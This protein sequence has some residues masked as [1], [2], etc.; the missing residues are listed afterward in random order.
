[1]DNPVGDELM[2]F[3]FGGKS[4][5]TAIAA[6]SLEEYDHKLRPDRLGKYFK[7]YVKNYVFDEFSDKYLGKQK[8]LEFMRGVPI[9]LRKEDLEAFKGDGLK[10]ML[11]AENMA[12]IIGIDPKF[13]YTKT[14]IQYM[15][16]F[17]GAKI[18][19]ALL[20]EGRN[21]A[22]KKDYD[23]AAIHLRAALCVKPDS[24]DALYSYARVCREMYLA[25][26]DPEYTGNFKAEA[27]EYFEFIVELHPKFAQAY[28]YLG[29]AYL[30]LG[31]YLKAKLTWNEFLNKSRSLKDKKEIRH[32]LEQLEQ[33]VEIE[34]G[35]N[36]VLAQRW[37]EGIAILEPYLNS[38]FKD[39]WPLSYYL[40]VCYGRTGKKGEA[41]V[42]LKKVLTLNPSHVE[43]MDELANIY[44]ENKDKT[45]EEKYRKKAELI[46]SGG[47]REKGGH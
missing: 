9:P 12:W 7:R 36:A 1:M 10:V 34:K 39:W 43:T 19:D 22:E 6:I 17:F 2:A 40:G 38:N 26:D 42:C 5:N 13:K 41:V 30:N 31:L 33:P 47:Y 32:R 3:L 28:Y 46:R 18:V 37:G 15:E 35:C 8:N 25:S 27:L 20:K 24:M 4:D 14:Y 21:A 44:A 11:I 16:K 23:N 29:Y 45:N